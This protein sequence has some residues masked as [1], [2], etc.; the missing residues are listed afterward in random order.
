MI[1]NIK[2]V[3]EILETQQLSRYTSEDLNLLLPEVLK[4][5]FG[6]SND[7]IE[8]F[9]YNAGEDLLNINYFYKDFKL[10]T[11]SYL[12]PTSGS[13]PIIEIDPVK[14]L[15]NLDYSSG[16]FIVQY[17][18]FNNKISNAQEA[19]LF[20]KEI[21]ADRT[22]LRIGSTFLTNEQIEK[23]TLS[24]INEYTGSSYF[25]DYLANF[26]NN[27]QVII[28]N[29]A[30]NKVESGY[31]I[32]LKLYQP[33]DIN[34][35]E[36]STLWI[37]KE[38]ISSYSFNINLDKLITLSPNI[39]LRGPN[40]DISIPNQN[41]I[42]T[43]YENYNSLINNTS[44]SYQQL[45]SLLTSQSI[46]INVNYSNFNNFSFFGSA[47]QR[48]LNFYGKVKEIEDYKNNITVY[49]A[50]TSSRPNLKNDL[51]LTTASINNIISNF[52][53]FEYYLYFE[54]GSL[55]SSIEYNITPYPKS[56]SNLPYT[57]FSTSSLSASIWLTY[58]T[59]SANEWD[60]YNSN[61]IVNTLPVFLK[62]D[63]NNAPYITF[64]D[65]VGHYFDNIWIFLQA[66][67]DINLANNNLEQGVSKDLVY[68]VL[69]S[70][71]VKL[72]N[73]YGDS[74]DFNFLIGN[75]TGSNV[76]DNNFT[77]TGSY[78]NNIPRKDLLAESYKR[79]YHNLPLLLKTKG[80]TYG[81]QTLIS[82]FGIPNLAYSTSY[83]ANG[84][85]SYYYITPSTGLGITSSILNVKEYGGGLKGSML[86]EYN[87]DKI[88]IVSSSIVTGSVLSP[89]ISVQN[90][91]VSTSQFRTNDLHYV[92]ISFSPETQID[93]YA[94]T[95]IATSNPTW[96]LDDFI[97]DPGYLY[98]SSYTAL[99]TEKNTY[100]NFTAS[101]MDYAG[102][103]R[104][105]Q[106]FDNSLFKM[107]K[108]FVP[109]RANL[110]T[111]ITISSP[112]LERNKWSYSN[113]SDTS[114]IDPKEG[115]IEG[116]TI[117]SE[118]T[119]LYNDLSN[120]KIAYYDGNIT[121]SS[122]NVHSYF[123]SGNV[124]PYLFDF[125][126]W[127]NGNPNESIDLYKFNYSDFN[128]LINNVSQSRESLIRKKIEPIYAINSSL[129]L[130]GYSASYNAELQDSYLSLQSHQLSRYEGVKLTS[131][132]YNT[133]TS[134]SYTGSDGFNQNGD[135]SYGKTAVIDKNTNKIG[136]FTE[137]K[138][139]IY[140]P[141][142][143]NVILKY[144]V[145]DKGRL[146][147]LNERNKNW[148]EV[149]RT[150]IAGDVLDI[151]L[152]NIQ[153]NQ[154]TTNG[155]KPIFDSGYSYNPILY[156]SS[157][158][159]DPIIYF[160]SLGES[161]AYTLNTINGLSPKTISGYSTNSYPVTGTPPNGNI[162]NIFDTVIEGASYYTTGSILNQLF[163]SYSIQ[164]SGNYK[165]NGSFTMDIF[166]PLG[167][168]ITWSFSMHKNNSELIK[169]VYN[170]NLSTTFN[171]TQIRNYYLSF[172]CSTDTSD[173]TIP[174]ELVG[175]L[176]SN[177]PSAG[178]YA[179]DVIYAYFVD[180]G[181]SSCSTINSEVLYSK[182]PSITMLVNYDCNSCDGLGTYSVWQ[183]EKVLGAA[184]YRIPNFTIDPS[185]RIS[186][187]FNINL[188]NISGLSKNDKI[189]PKLVLEGT[190]TNN[191][192][193]SISA[194]NL[195]ISSL[196]TQTGYASTTC[197]YFDS[198]ALSSSVV[199][200]DR[201]TL[202][203]SSG[204]SNFHN[205]DY[206]FAP[207]PIY[208]GS[209]GILAS[210]SLY[211]IYKDVDY[212]FNIKPFDI[213]LTYLS[214]GTYVE[215]RVLSVTSSNGF[216]QT[217]LD[218]VMTDKQISDFQSGSYQRF[219]VLSRKEDETN[220]YVT[221]K[222][223]DGSTSYGFIIPSNISSTF[224]DNIDTITREVKQR[225]INEQL[226]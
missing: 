15:Q 127:N 31:E 205:R 204:L 174:G 7:Y 214:D 47:E 194:G 187:T 62:D 66:V 134:S 185:G 42:S 45:L 74:N 183:S 138:E 106:F 172:P 125:T 9:V 184:L 190:T 145:D 140:L 75:N 4:E 180:T 121:G 139:S 168:Q 207:N 11:T 223:R 151:S 160:E 52:D 218:T 142:R 210:N 173:K 101:Y 137:I 85:A 103:T 59:A 100:Y 89:Y 53:G 43:A 34:I 29:V 95:S 2:I 49:T 206:I 84:S 41:N 56:G 148:C 224:L 144:L 181:I 102:F 159:A 76:F 209:L 112:V 37:V 143:N 119:T 36:K 201:N 70:L 108:D 67:T 129:S 150:F 22:E 23:S 149:Q 113:P 17:N 170:I 33:L 161:N 178:F 123:V 61:Y 8:Y 115:T 83:D 48:I 88:R 27:Q 13:L 117:G 157:C 16:E 38:K 215:S 211:P 32:F 54:S 199:A 132:K 55:T 116:P 93:T 87:T 78:L 118:Y 57:L 154:K 226:L 177:I 91:P 58:A 130:T 131:L 60:N 105:I 114:K 69:Q 111:G 200:G 182:N 146:T 110:S 98:S 39:Q 192:T 153:N 217:K 97:G 155:T 165:V 162:Y 193:A 122:I 152:F 18:F 94:S 96:S 72:Y 6:Q 64:L 156:F 92:D 163:P 63:D 203:F 28:V 195:T 222:K 46:D 126:N 73:K 3:G 44:S 166:M 179:G 24:I 90:L 220:A 107:L 208:T 30:L 219:L 221:F 164:E 81:L 212:P 82:T 167:G 19:G 135:I 40:F 26:G 65:M 99:N 175:T 216:V 198:T 86:D 196:A 20:I 104:L 109:A 79:I 202:T 136:L 10:P 213:I 186:Q 191:Y 35:Q 188:S 14:D 176:T 1:N 141:K 197:N 120:N 128:I 124:N 158:S 80:T 77:P 133:Y 51:N 71:G 50:L 5:N 169:Q 12:D 21:S 171:A 25:V 68:Y 225:L 147:E 189:I